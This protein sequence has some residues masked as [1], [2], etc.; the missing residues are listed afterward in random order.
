M[1]NTV[2][3]YTDGAYSPTKQKGG[4]GLYCPQY[5]LKMCH[6][7]YNTTNNRME[8][9]AAIRALEFVDESI[10]NIADIEN[11]DEAGFIVAVSTKYASQVLDTL[12][13]MKIKNVF[14]EKDLYRE[15]VG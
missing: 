12:R 1:N 11:P 5:K 9:T 13:N 8:M 6:G 2:I 3:F 15:V 4:W 10:Y 7:E 14:Y